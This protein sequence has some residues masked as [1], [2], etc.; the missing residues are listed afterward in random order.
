[1]TKVSL[2]KENSVFEYTCYDKYPVFAYPASWGEVVRI[3]DENGFTITQTFR[4][5]LTT[6]QVKSGEMISYYVY[7]LDHPVG[8][9]LFQIKFMFEEE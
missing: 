2:S 4:K 6:Y 1:M 8:I 7:V 5:V 9:D 3:R